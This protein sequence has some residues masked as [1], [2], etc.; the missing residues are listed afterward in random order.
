MAPGLMGHDLNSTQPRAN[1][2]G[3]VQS[4]LTENNNDGDAKPDDRGDQYDPIDR[5]GPFVVFVKALQF[6]FHF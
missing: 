5:N 4:S 1:T 3:L 2:G 6:Q